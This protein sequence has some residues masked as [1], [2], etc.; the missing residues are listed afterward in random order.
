M[1]RALAFFSLLL[2][3]AWAQSINCDASDLRYDFGAS[4]FL[5]QETVGGVPYPVANLAAYLDLLSQ[6]SSKR[7][8]PTTAV[9]GLGRYVECVASA[10]TRSGGGG[11]IC[12]ARN[13]WCLRITNVTGVFPVDWTTRLYVL[14]QLLSCSGGCTNHVPGVTLI[15]ALPDNRGLLSLSPGATATF[16]VYFLVELSPEDTFIAFPATGSLTFTYGYQRN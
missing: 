9:G 12:G 16:R 11:T 15:S 13:D 2:F 14:V 8:L 10:P 1:G 6:S 5:M 7:F 3:P 4:G